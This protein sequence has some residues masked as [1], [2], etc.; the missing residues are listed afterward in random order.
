MSWTPDEAVEFE[1]AREA[2]TDMIAM[3]TAWIAEE[4]RKDAP[5]AA[6]IETWRGEIFRLAKE[7]SALHAHDHAFHQAG[8][9][10]TV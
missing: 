5:D 9:F 3:R 10:P 8:K 7:R 1:C 4:N 6:L 2:I